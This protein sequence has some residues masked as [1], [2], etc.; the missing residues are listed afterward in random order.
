MSVGVLALLTAGLF[1]CLV[2]GFIG[3]I[4]GKFKNN[5]MAGFWFGFFLSA[6]GWL[7]T[8]LLPDNRNAQ[9]SHPRMT[10]INLRAKCAAN[11]PFCGK[12][13]EAVTRKCPSCGQD[14]F[15]NE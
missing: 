12:F 10:P 3:M 4:I 15:S 6:I 14:I 5:E 1:V 11:C 13:T 8:A 2:N 9:E 7:I